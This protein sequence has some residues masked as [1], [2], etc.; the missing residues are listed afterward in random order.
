MSSTFMSAFDDLSSTVPSCSISESSDLASAA[1]TLRDRRGFTLSLTFAPFLPN[2]APK[3]AL[4]PSLSNLPRRKRSSVVSIDLPAPLPVPAPAP[5]DL[6][7]TEY[8]SAAHEAPLCPIQGRT[9]SSARILL[10]LSYVYIIVLYE[11]LEGLQN[12]TSVVLL[13]IFQTKNSKSQKNSIN[14][15]RSSDLG[16]TYSDIGC[17][18]PARFQLR[19]AA[20]IQRA[21]LCVQFKSGPRPLR[22]SLVAR[23]RQWQ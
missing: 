19:H 17:M 23:S 6:G 22:A 16:V 9:S 4:G 3:G 5:V 10:W 15:F 1:L 18:G 2:I 8:F 20:D 14:S 12:F 7:R 21:L 11:H 13:H